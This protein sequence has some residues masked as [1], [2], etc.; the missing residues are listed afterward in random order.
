MCL[1]VPGILTWRYVLAAL[2]FWESALHFKR[3]GDLEIWRF[4]SLGE[5]FDDGRWEMMA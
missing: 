4:G 2:E 5:G 1:G 3:F